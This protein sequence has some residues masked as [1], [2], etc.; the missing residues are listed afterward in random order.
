MNEPN[1][2]LEKI[3][4]LS[5]VGKSWVRDVLPH[6]TKNT[7]SSLSTAN[8]KAKAFSGNGFHKAIH[9]TKELYAFKNSGIMQNA[10]KR[11]LTPPEAN[12]A[13]KLAT[14]IAKKTV[15]TQGI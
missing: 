9:S 3:A 12:R 15:K 8:S 13:V 5:I 2:Y 4:S 1:K 10:L 14:G 11:G 7:I 6:L